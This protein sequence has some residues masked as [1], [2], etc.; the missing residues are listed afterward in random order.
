ARRPARRTRRPRRSAP[1]TC[2]YGGLG[3]ERTARAVPVIGSDVRLKLTDSLL[4]GGA[5]STHAI[6]TG[7]TLLQFEADATLRLHRNVSL[8]A[9]YRFIESTI[10]MSGPDPTLDQEGVFARL[11]IKF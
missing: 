2:G 10:D 6:A 4:L 8:S 11:V 3:D 7:A 5:A 1:R 9:G